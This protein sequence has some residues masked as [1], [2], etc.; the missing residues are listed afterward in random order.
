MSSTSP[1]LIY[2]S[3]CILVSQIEIFHENLPMVQLIRQSGLL[4]SQTDTT[5]QHNNRSENMPNGQKTLEAWRNSNQGMSFMSSGG[6]LH[7]FRVRFRSRL[8]RSRA[9]CRRLDLFARAFGRTLAVV[10][11]VSYGLVSPCFLDF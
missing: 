11:R 4:V 7:L 9:F 2:R 1:M 6:K 3:P 10:L 8:G 5:F